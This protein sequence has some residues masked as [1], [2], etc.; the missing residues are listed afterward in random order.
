MVENQIKLKLQPG[1][2][3]KFV[4]KE[5][6]QVEVEIGQPR[7]VDK[8]GK[9]VSPNKSKIKLTP[10]GKLEGAQGGAAPVI[11]LKPQPSGK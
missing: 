4:T 5:G 3:Q 8:S 11:K 1:S 9:E 10:Q 2:K 7:Y 6:K